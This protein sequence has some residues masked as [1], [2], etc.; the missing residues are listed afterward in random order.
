ML[1][2][3]L[4]ADSVAVEVYVFYE[5][6]GSN[7]HTRHGGWDDSLPAAGWTDVGEGPHWEESCANSR[8]CRTAAERAANR[9]VNPSWD[10]SRAAVPG[11]G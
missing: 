6:G 7:G 8:L 9:H 3:S 4:E 2:I 5:T 10:A 11:I 1:T